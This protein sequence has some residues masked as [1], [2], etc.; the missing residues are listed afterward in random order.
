MNKL[1]AVLM[2]AV[3][4]TG[5]FARTSIA[6]N[7]QNTVNHFKRM[8]VLTSE[9]T[10][11]GYNKPLSAIDTI[12]LVAKHGNYVQDSLYS[13]ILEGLDIVYENQSYMLDQGLKKLKYNTNEKINSVYYEHSER[14][15][16]NEESIKKLEDENA[17][18][19]IALVV[20]TILGVVF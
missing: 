18:L 12:S 9:R 11:A 8:G 15:E 17:F 5:V 20:G 10:G 4:S 7:E 19:K 14:F 2:I 13:E 1:L 3:C 6:Q 16:K